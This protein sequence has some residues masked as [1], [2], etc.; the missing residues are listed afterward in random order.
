MSDLGKWKGGGT[1]ER[2]MREVERVMMDF[3]FFLQ[4][5]GSAKRTKPL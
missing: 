5:R 2:E 1:K 4:K 3:F